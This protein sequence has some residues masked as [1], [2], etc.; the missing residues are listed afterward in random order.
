MKTSA[1]IIDFDGTLCDAMGR[2]HY[3]TGE[4]K[5]YDRFYEAA[6]FCQPN[7]WCVQIIKRFRIDYKI[8]IVTGQPVKFK[9][10][11]KF[12]MMKY[13]IHYDHLWC[14]ATDDFRKDAVIK[15]ELYEKSIEPDHE[16]LF[17]IDD[18]KQVVDMW[19]SLGLTVLQCEEGN[20]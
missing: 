9:D 8:I 3:V 12:W 19:R 15:K 10:N 20:F 18:R 17:C 4:D 11:I 5:N 2:R 6:A 7:W 16:V 13:G 1:I 14:R